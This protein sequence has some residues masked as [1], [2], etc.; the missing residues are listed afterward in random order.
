MHNDDAAAASSTGA[1]QRMSGPNFLFLPYFFDL[2][3]L[4]LSLRVQGFK[5][6][7]PR[8]AGNAAIALYAPLFFFFSSSSLGRRPRTMM[9]PRH[10]DN[11][12]IARYAP[13]AHVR[14]PPLFLLLC[15]PSP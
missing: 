8:D 3:Y 9:R 11:G 4:F 15:L 10:A 12:A 5:T 14:A 1:P 13:L 6:T 2:H 7:R